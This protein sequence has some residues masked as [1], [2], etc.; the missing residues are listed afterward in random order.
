[1]PSAFPVDRLILTSKATVR[2]LNRPDRFDT[3]RG[4]SH[5]IAGRR[6]IGRSRADGWDPL[7]RRL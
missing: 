1:M 6:P 2:V 7:A 5:L 4:R 3:V